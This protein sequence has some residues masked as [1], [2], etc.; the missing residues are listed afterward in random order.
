[1]VGLDDLKGKMI[2]QWSYELSTLHFA[3]NCLTKRTASF[4]AGEFA[5]RSVCCWVLTDRVAAAGQT[6]LL[7]AQA[8]E[9][10]PAP[11]A[12]GTIGVIRAPHAVAPVARGAVQLRV[13]VAL[14][15]PPVAVTSCKDKGTINKEH[16]GSDRPCS[17]KTHY[18]ELDENCR[19]AGAEAFN[20]PESHAQITQG[21]CA[22]MR[23]RRGKH[24]FVI[25]KHRQ[26]KVKLQGL[27]GLLK[28]TLSYIQR[29]NQHFLTYFIP[30][31]AAI[32]S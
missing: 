29:E 16:K 25:V 32:C 2:P 4:C 3:L 31:Q 11:L 1:M 20:H 5:N 17:H 8:I 24:G 19:G 18:T 27:N 7:A 10:V 12:V 22:S 28:T 13:K 15:R 23:S 6:S 21:F 9:A 14:L 30:L 26:G